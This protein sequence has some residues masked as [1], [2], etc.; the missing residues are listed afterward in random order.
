MSNATGCTAECAVPIWRTV[1]SMAHT[2]ES[3]EVVVFV[4]AVLL[5]LLRVWWVLK[6]VSSSPT[7][8][9]PGRFVDV[10]LVA[11][12]SAATLQVERVPMMMGSGPKVTTVLTGPFD[13]PAN[14]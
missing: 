2:S 5:L 6:F 13:N 7:L 1:P 8:T 4:V 12:G 14:E 3:V 10:G 9:R 11:D